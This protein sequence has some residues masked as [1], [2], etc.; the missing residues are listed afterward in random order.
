ML[1]PIFTVITIIT[2]VTIFFLIKKVN[3]INSLLSA[4]MEKNNN[5]SAQITRLKDHEI[6]YKLISAQSPVGIA[7]LQNDRVQYVNQAMSDN[8]GY[9]IDEMLTWDSFRIF[10]GFSQDERDLISQQIKNDT[11]DSQTDS[12]LTFTF[13]LRRKNGDKIWVSIYL[14]SVNYKGD[15][16]TLVIMTDVTELKLIEEQLYQS[17]KMDSIGQ[18]AGGVAHDFNN[19]L[20]GIIGASEL[21]ELKLKDRP[22]LL[23]FI[24]LIKDSSNRASELTHQ[25][26]DFSRKEK[27]CLN[28]MNMHDTVTKSVDIL[29]RSIDKMIII[30]QDLKA[31]NPI[32][33]GNVAQIQN[34]ILNI[35]LN[36]RDAMPKGGTL[37]FKSHNKEL[38][39]QCCAK[40]NNKLTPG[41]YIIIEIN[42]TG[43]GI[44]SEI[45][46]HIFEPF[47]TTK[48][49]SKGTGLGLATVYKTIQN[50]NGLIDVISDEGIGTTFKLFL[51]TCH[52]DYDISENS[53][54]VIQG[55]GTILLADD[56]PIV[57]AVT[58]QLLN[59][60]GYDIISAK[61]GDEAVRKYN[62]NIDK[63]DLVILDMVMPEMNGPTCFNKIR[64]I[65]KDAKIIAISGFTR[66][67]VTDELLDKGLLGFI[68][69]PINRIELS[70]VIAKSINT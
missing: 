9:S 25:L 55:R 15:T 49:S 51:P 30:E 48:G 1:L 27:I 59:E 21:L 42:D 38:S 53:D 11:R 14:K 54:E 50:H 28:P 43:T 18:L 29:K 70:N 3:S 47:F 34:A 68:K 63:I 10:D 24:N 17:Q 6:I 56:E 2:I 39:E 20:G 16:A 22:D 26:L 19:T 62:E 46:E 44:P 8:N 12:K 64:E 23:E 7:I 66:E 60:I 67:M 37:T 41:K 5:L 4:T 58:E 31:N 13:K 45:R 57:R 33:R 35:A 52:T 61:N 65:N 36:A 40:Y 69:K 32:I